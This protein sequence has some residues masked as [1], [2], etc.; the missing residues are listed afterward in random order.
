MVLPTGPLNAHPLTDRLNPRISPPPTPGPPSPPTHPVH[1]CGPHTFHFEGREAELPHPH[2]LWQQ[3]AVG[4]KTQVHKT[5]RPRLCGGVHQV[6][7][8]VSV[9]GV[10]WVE[11]VGQEVWIGCTSDQDME[12]RT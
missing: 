6:L 12:T 4:R 3:R 8:P 10:V 2:R 1:T 11:G 9:G 5:L 7:Q